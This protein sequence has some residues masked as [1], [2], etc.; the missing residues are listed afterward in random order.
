MTADILAKTISPLSGF[1]GKEQKQHRASS[2]NP[3]LAEEHGED[4]E[5]KAS[6]AL[7]E[8]ILSSY[9]PVSDWELAR[10]FGN[11]DKDDSFSESVETET[12]PLVHETDGIPIVQTGTQEPETRIASAAPAREKS[13]GIFSDSRI[14]SAMIQHEL[15][16]HDVTIKHFHHPAS[17][18][19]ERFDFFDSIDAW[20]VFLSDDYEGDFL[21]QFLERYDDKPTLFLFEKCQ[22]RR[23]ARNIDQ[24]LTENTLTKGSHL[25]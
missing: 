3:F 16:R 19:P 17:F 8:E 23:T 7:R 20:M 25:A 22:R 21:E 15:K 18:R 11:Y 13:L 24:F 9:I 1:L 6:D 2:S 14:Y 10:I 5:L 4:W 12:I